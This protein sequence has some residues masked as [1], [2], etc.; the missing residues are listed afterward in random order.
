MLVKTQFC[1]YC[2][3]ASMLWKELQKE[4]KFEYEE[5]D[6]ATPK[7]Q[8]L[9]MKFN[10]MAVPTN[11]IETNGKTNVILGLLNRDKAIKAISG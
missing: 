2:P 10:I 3:S 6:A 1:V 8:D 7:G 9:V 5:I 4:Y 11:I